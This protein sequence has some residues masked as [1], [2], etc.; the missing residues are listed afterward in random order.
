MPTKKQTQIKTHEDTLKDFKEAEEQYSKAK[1]ALSKAEIEN[2][3]EKASL[4]DCVTGFQK[5]READIQNKIK[6]ANMVN[7]IVSEMTS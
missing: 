1:Q 6:I 3:P 7:E 5:Q 2:M 4:R